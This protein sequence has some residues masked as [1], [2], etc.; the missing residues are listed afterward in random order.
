MIF[1]ESDSHETETFKASAEGAR[2][3]LGITSEQ[4]RIAHRID[5]LLEP[6]EGRIDR[7]IEALPYLR[8][9][10]AVAFLKKY[11]S[12]PQTDLKHLSI[13]EIC[14]AAGVDPRH[15]LWLAAD[16][17]TNRSLS[18]VKLRVFGS[19][20]AIVNVAVENALTQIKKTSGLHAVKKLLQ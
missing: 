10:A 17:L 4:M 18:V 5:P 13:E 11:D 16:G 2:E 7:I 9:S 15:L 1:R 12:V 19:P 3:R 8:Y 6:F 20:P 14:I